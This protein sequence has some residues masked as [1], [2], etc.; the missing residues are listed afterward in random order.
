MPELTTVESV[1][2]TATQTASAVETIIGRFLAGELSPREAAA[3][4]G[5]SPDHQQTCADELI[6]L[7]E[8]FDVIREVLAGKGKT[9][10]LLSHE[11]PF[12]VDF[13]Y[14]HSANDL[15]GRL[16]RGSIPLKMAIAEAAPDIVFSGHMHVEG[17]M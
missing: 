16:H 7:K 8:E 15:R 6:E 10:I 4:L 12:Y 2:Q 9:T 14:H 17:R 13:D 1:T 5:V 11:S 3:E